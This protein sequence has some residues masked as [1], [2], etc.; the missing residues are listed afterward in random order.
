MKKQKNKQ[1]IDYAALSPYL[2][3]II[4]GLKDKEELKKR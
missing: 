3:G 1:P 4:K 2:K